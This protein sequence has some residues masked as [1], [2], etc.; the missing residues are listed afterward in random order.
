MKKCLFILVFL[1]SFFLTVTY[2]YADEIIIEPILDEEKE[3]DDE[4]KDENLLKGT[5]NINNTKSYVN[6]PMQATAI[7][8]YTR[9]S[10]SYQYLV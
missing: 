3:I 9:Y 2:C 4:I 5:G 6:D 1:L 8:F 10:T 7:Q